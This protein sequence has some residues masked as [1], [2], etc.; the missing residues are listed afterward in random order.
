MKYGL[1]NWNDIAENFLKNKTAG[2][3]EEHY[4][5]NIYRTR[6]DVKKPF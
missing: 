3:C 2:Q 6:E 5:G 4:F 1:G